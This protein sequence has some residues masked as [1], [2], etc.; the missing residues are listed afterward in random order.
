MNAIVVKATLDDVDDFLIEVLGFQ[1]TLKF[2]G[3]FV[4]KP[5]LYSLLLHKRR[6]FQHGPDTIVFTGSSQVRS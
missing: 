5:E 1:Q 4:E 2:S 6:S 3:K